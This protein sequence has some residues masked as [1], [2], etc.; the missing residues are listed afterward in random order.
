MRRRLHEATAHR[1]DALLAL[2][3]DVNIAPDLGADGLSEFLDIVAKGPRFET[4]LDEGASLRLR[5]TDTD[6]TWTIR[7]SGDTITYSDSQAPAALTIQGT[8]VDLYLLLLRRIPAESPRL[9][10]SGDL[11]VLTTWLERIKF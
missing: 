7:R 11:L 3:R 5:A 10:V 6:D 9:E 8:A 2:D 1:A 4:P